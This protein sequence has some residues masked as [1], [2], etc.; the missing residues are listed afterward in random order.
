MTAE[1]RNETRPRT[2]AQETEEEVREAL[3]SVE[4]ED[5][6]KT[7]EAGDA[8]RPDREAEEEAHG[9]PGEPAP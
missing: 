9:E 7:G 8:L 6:Q 1:H 2:A 5:R 3:T 4:G